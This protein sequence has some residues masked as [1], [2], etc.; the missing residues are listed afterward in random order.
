[1]NGGGVG[2][3]GWGQGHY[4]EQPTQ[5]AVPAACPLSLLEPPAHA[6]Q[7]LTAYMQESANHEAVVRFA[8]ELQTNCTSFLYRSSTCD[9]CFDAASAA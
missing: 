5:L 1:M 7:L 8:L 3:G 6:S 4:L 9:S 2:V